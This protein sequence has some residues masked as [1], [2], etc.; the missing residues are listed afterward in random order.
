ML[1]F[2]LSQYLSGG[3]VSYQ[4]M[5]KSFKVIFVNQQ[6]LIIIVNCIQLDQLVLAC[7]L[8]VTDYGCGVSFFLIKSWI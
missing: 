4:W 6:I 5:D 3:S 7:H 2:K 8:R 1:P